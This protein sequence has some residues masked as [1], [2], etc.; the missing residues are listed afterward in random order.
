MIV[1]NIKGTSDR[2]PYGYD[3]WI[4]FWKSKKG[5][6]PTYCNCENC[7]EDKDLVGGHVQEDGEDTRDF[8]YIL[9]LCRKHNHFTNTKPFKVFD[10]K[11]LIR[12]TEDD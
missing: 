2:E 9:P 3:S 5:S 7:T 4:D 6:N 1:H 11:D 10:E 12:I 8:W